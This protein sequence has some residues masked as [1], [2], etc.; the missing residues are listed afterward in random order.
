[1]LAYN[2]GQEPI[3]V[4]CEHRL[5]LLSAAEEANPTRKHRVLTQRNPDFPPRRRDMLQDARGLHSLSGQT[6]VSLSIEVTQAI[7]KARAAGVTR[8]DVLGVIRQ[9]L[10]SHG[11]ELPK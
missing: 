1:M 6:L 11:Y 3:C 9:T 7:H 4:G 5:N 8:D 2:E 10:A